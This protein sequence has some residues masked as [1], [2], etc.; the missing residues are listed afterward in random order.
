MNCERAVEVLTHVEGRA[1]VG[2][3]LDHAK[4]HLAACAACRDSVAAV[5]ALRV[6]AGRSVPPPSPDAFERALD[7]AIGRVAPSRRLAP[8]WMGTGLGAALAAGIAAAVILLAPPT[9][10]RV[11]PAATPRIALAADER[12][13]VSIALMAPEALDDAEIHVLVS[14]AIGLGGFEGQRE[15]LWRTRLDAGA[16]QLTLPVVA[17]GTGGGQLLVEVRHGEKRRRFLVDV[18]TGVGRMEEGA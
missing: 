10:E 15:L 8:F 17:T 6:D 1:G 4:L 9:A 13:D 5:R 11:S 14:G 7:A 16:N 2:Q 3:D 12:R 18:D